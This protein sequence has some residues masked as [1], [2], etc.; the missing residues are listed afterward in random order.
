MKTP[1]NRGAR[2]ALLA[3]V[4][5]HVLAIAVYALA[6]GHNLLR[7]MITG[8]KSWRHGTLPHIEFGSVWRALFG[9]ALAAMLV[10]YIA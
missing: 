10:W 4:A 6:K 5:L 2:V 9:M 1:S 8:S 3:A 7:P